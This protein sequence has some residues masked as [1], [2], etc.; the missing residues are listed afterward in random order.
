METILVGLLAGVIGAGMT[1]LLQIRGQRL[2]QLRTR[3]I[4]AADEL[5]SAAAEV[6][7]SLTARMQ[8]L[9]DPPGREAAWLAGFKAAS[10]EAQANMHQATRAFP[11]IELLFGVNSP[12]GAA[13]AQ[14]ISGLFRMT[15]ELRKQPG[16]RQV[17]IDNYQGA[18]DAFGDFNREAN[19]VITLPAWRQRRW[20][21]GG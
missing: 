3:Q 10:D 16:S 21:K 13:G 1:G 6:F 4:S 9:G 18:A 2:D 14:M 15:E 8:S 7:V 5:T 20:T 11:R 12:T 17:V 19:R